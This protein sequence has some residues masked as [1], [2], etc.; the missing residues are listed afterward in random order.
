[1]ETVLFCCGR[2]APERPG[3][4]HFTG[5]SG[6]MARKSISRSHSLPSF[7]FAMP[8]SPFL[9]SYYAPRPARDAKGV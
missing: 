4:I 5:L 8:S 7:V 3:S 1:M 6:H 9:T 2:G